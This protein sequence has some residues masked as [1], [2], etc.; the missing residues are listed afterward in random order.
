MKKLTSQ[1]LASFNGGRR[2]VVTKSPADVGGARPTGLGPTAGVAGTRT[3]GTAPT[4][5]TRSIDLGVSGAAVGLRLAQINNLAGAAGSV[6]N[7]SS[8][9][10]SP[11]ATSRIS[12]NRFQLLSHG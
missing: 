8:V 4:G 11:M 10:S 7:T 6:G 9:S 2:A 5:G 1:E 12:V 3:A